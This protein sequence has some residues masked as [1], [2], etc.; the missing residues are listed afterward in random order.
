MEKITSKDGTIIGFT[1]SGKGRPL[2]LI[3]GTTADHR[4]W[5]SIKP[6]LE[7][8]FTVYAMDR[9]G[10]GSSTDTQDYHIMREAEDVA[11]VVDAV[12]GQV[13]VLGHS[14][15]LSVVSKPPY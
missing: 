3:H 2:L 9:R 13:A 12:S 7:E 15:A 10:R 11:A 8:H 5:S 14:L 4:R 6:R 1:R